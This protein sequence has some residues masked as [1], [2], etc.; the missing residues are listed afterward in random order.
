MKQNRC[1]KAGITS[2]HVPLPA[3]TTS[4]QLVG[5]LGDLSADPT[6]R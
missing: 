4:G 2:R 6:P 3:D 5:T 1:R